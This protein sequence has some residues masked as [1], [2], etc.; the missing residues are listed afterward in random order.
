MDKAVKSL[1]VKLVRSFTFFSGEAKPKKLK[2]SKRKKDPDITFWESHSHSRAS[3]IRKLAFNLKIIVII[4]AVAT[5]CSVRYRYYVKMN[6]ESDKTFL[7]PGI[8]F[9][10][11]TALYMFQCYFLFWIWIGNF[12][13]IWPLLLALLVIDVT[14]LSVIYKF[15]IRRRLITPVLKVFAGKLEVPKSRGPICFEWADIKSITRGKSYFQLFMKNGKVHFVPMKREDIGTFASMA[16]QNFS[17]KVETGFC[18]PSTKRL[19]NLLLH[20][21]DIAIGNL[22]I[23][24][25]V[26]FSSGA[27]TEMIQ[28]ASWSGNIQAVQLLQFFQRIPF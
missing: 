18:F 27:R 28:I 17:E 23:T 13:V 16:E 20:R 26:G 2:W 1:T 22:L 15:I 10:E 6:T 7:S 12:K 21:Y 19:I 11:P 24:A 8:G 3:G 9:G 4:A 25:L 5:V 14:W